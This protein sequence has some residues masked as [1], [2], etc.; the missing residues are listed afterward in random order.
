MPDLAM[1]RAHLALAERDIL[2]GEDRVF[3]QE[4]LVALMRS[5]NQD[6]TEAEALLRLLRETLL[7]WRAHRDQILRTIANLQN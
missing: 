6:T 2:E 5:R 3:R 7:I 4:E 1:E